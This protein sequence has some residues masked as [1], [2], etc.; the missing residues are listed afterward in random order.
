MFR[1]STATFGTSFST[2]CTSSVGKGLNA[3]ILRRPA[4]YPFSRKRPDGHPGGARHGA[5]RHEDD[6][7]VFR[8]D[9]FYRRRS[10]CP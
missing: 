1:S 2:S 8:V 9:G 7:R 3:F 10:P 6:L 5:A 4:L